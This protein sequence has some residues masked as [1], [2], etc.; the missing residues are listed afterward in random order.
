MNTLLD[1]EIEPSENF[2]CFLKCLSEETELLNNNGK[3]DLDNFYPED[4]LDD[5]EGKVEECFGN[6]ERIRDCEDMIQ[7]YECFKIF[8]TS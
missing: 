4:I 8:L 6:V 2:L 1:P 3:I 5:V 7:I